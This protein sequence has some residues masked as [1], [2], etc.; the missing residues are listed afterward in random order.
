MSKIFTHAN[1]CCILTS[2]KKEN[3]GDSTHLVIK[4]EEIDYEVTSKPQVES[5]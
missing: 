4:L 3:I 1:R 5:F 2:T